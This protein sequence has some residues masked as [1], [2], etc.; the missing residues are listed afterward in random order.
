MPSSGDGAF[1]GGA[2]L[3]PA[4]ST[5]IGETLAG[6]GMGSVLT[7]VA[8]TEA[9]L[10]GS[11]AGSWDSSGPDMVFPATGAS[12]LPVATGDGAGS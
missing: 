9:P 2:V 3:V 12:S 1:A 5:S 6:R 10:L 4:R 11:G 8:G 7:L